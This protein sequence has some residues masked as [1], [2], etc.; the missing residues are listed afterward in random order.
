MRRIT[1]I[2]FIAFLL[3]FEGCDREVSLDIPQSDTTLVANSIFTSDSIL[4]LHLSKSDGGEPVQDATIELFQNKS[5]IGVFGHIDSSLYK[6]DDLSLEQGL[7]YSI[8]IQVPGYKELT[9]RDTIPNVIPIL[10]V[11]YNDSVGVVSSSFSSNRYLYSSFEITF[12]DPPGEKNY[13]EIFILR[14]ADTSSL[15]L[16][17][18]TDTDLVFNGISFWEIEKQS[19]HEQNMTLFSFDQSIAT[20][21][22]SVPERI[23]PVQDILFFSDELFNGSEKTI[24]VNCWP[25][26]TE[27]YRSSSFFVPERK[28]TVYLRSVSK[29]YYSFRKTQKIY[30]ELIRQEDIWRGT[31]D[32]LQVYSNIENGYGLFAAYAVSLDSIVVNNTYTP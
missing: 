25:Y 2:Q 4:H 14:E 27:L 28:F 7:A 26:Y 20:E 1:T 8:I 22:F 18:S 29:Q 24:R 31:G 5:L 16:W 10:D 12:A 30:N 13:Y 17:D 19:L 32:Y 3:L 6:Y 15:V 23:F 9:A 21:G 11:N